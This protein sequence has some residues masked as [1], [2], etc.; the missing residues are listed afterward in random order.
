MNS[1]DDE[2]DHQ[3]DPSAEQPSSE[4][5]ITVDEPR[6]SVKRNVGI[7]LVTQVITWSISLVLIV[8]LPRYLGSE[9]IG[10]YRLV[11]S[12]WMIAGTFVALGTQTVITLDVARRQRQG[13][14]EVVAPVIIVRSTAFLVVS[15]VVALFVAVADYDSSI[16]TLFVIAGVGTLATNIGGIAINALQGFENFSL[17]SLANIVDKALSTTIIMAALVF[18]ASVH[19]IMAIAVGSAAVHAVLVF[20]FLRRYVSLRVRS[21]ARDAVRMARRGLPFL[22]GGFAIVA[23]HEMDTVLMS[24]LVDDEQIGWYAAADRL[25]ASS[26][27]IP[28]IVMSALFPTFARLNQQDPSVA[29]SLVE[30]GFRSLILFSI[31]IGFGL[32]TISSPLTLLLFG[33][34]FRESGPVLAVL[35]IVLMLM[36]QTI[37]IGN[38]AV[39]TGH[40]KFYFTLI[41]IGVIATIP[42]DLVLV[43]WTNRT[44]DN[45]A[46]GGALAYI[47][48][49]SAI[50]IVATW[51]F[52]P[53]VINRATAARLAK[54]VVAGTAMVIAIWPLRWVVLIVPIGVGAVVYVA[55][56]LLLSTFTDEERQ[57]ISS[58]VD[59]AKGKFAALR[60]RGA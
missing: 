41:F 52:A 25:T 10:Q 39:A 12:V 7:L 34:E 57:G 30:R 59:R 6:R 38:Y 5:E 24:L 51:R 1:G 53:H 40:E 20:V 37:L 13:A 45:G 55:V 56:V 23:Y 33:E 43:P 18:G 4:H 42:L 27:F 15:C 48:T 2:V 44:F 17:P 32:A 9:A 19:T 49:E 26:L 11:T 35:S 14:A 47:V 8:A 60:A 3:A 54:C 58:T 36:F 50:L 16:A 28:T 22:F 21:S 31:P 29:Q 46:I